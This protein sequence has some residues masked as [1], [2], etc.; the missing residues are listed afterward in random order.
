MSRGSRH[1]S[2]NIGPP[3]PTEEPEA[4]FAYADSRHPQA[5]ASG[6]ARGKRAG[7]RIR[8]A[9]SRTPGG[10]GETGWGARKTLSCAGALLSPVLVDV[11]G[12]VRARWTEAVGPLGHLRA[13]RVAKA[14]RAPFSGLGNTPRPQ[15]PVICVWKSF[16]D[17]Q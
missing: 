15:L 5:R 16:T 9:S 17:C 7:M 14:W 1:P 10:E 4:T 13:N 6:A 3:S 11:E 2:K 8:V 12:S